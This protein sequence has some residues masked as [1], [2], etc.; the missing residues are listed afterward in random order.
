VNSYRLQ[1]PLDVTCA[2]LGLIVLSPLLVAVALL[3]VL[4][5]GAPILFQQVRVGRHGRY[6]RIWKFR[7][8]R[9]GSTGRA[10]TVS[11]DDRIT[12]VG[13]VLRKYKLDELPQL[14]NVLRGDMSMVGP[15]P[16]APAY[17]QP[18]VPAWRTVL[19]AR[20][21]ITDLAS[22]TYRDEEKLLER[23]TDWEAFYRNEVQ[24]A[25]LALNLAY[26]KK[27][28]LWTDLRLIVLT[29]RHS[30]F[31]GAACAREE[32]YDRHIHPLSLSI[33]R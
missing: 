25:K 13:R 22:L 29:V 1:R 8:M 14:F 12:S 9:A 6:F 31:P 3:I 10:I 15:R 17:V 5:D 24:P 33:D 2:A 30:F 4:L 21:G 20:P 28:S 27:R 11:G 18:D 23:Q 26:L 32:Q 16:E 7:S 19:Q